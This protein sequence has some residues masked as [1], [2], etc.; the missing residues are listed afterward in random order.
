[1]CSLSGTRKYRK[2]KYVDHRK[3]STLTF[4]ILHDDCISNFRLIV[5][6]GNVSVCRSASWRR[7]FVIC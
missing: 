7:K 3:P 5:I 4:S 2:P 1:M 6:L